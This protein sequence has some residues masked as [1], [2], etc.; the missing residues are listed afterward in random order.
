MRK[1]APTYLELRLQPSG[2]RCLALARAGT[3]GRHVSRRVSWLV[4]GVL[5]AGIHG[6]NQCC[7]L[8]WANDEWRYQC[9]QALR[10]SS[11]VG[12]PVSR[13]VNRVLGA[14]VG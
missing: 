10:S 4:K 2:A 5:R 11:Y 6:R 13:L 7:G 8:R 14:W 9:M 1:N 3:G 12:R